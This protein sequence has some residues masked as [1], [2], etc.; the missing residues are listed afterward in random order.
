MLEHASVDPSNVARFV[1]HKLGTMAGDTYSAGA[2][3]DLA[4]QTA[5]MVKHAKAAE[6]AVAGL[7]RSR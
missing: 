2:S 6:T 7:P 5:R 1:G 4:V 3:K